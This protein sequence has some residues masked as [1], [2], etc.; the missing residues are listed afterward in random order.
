MNKVHTNFLRLL[1]N[2]L[3]DKHEPVDCTIEEVEYEAKNHICIPFIYKGAKN[4]EISIPQT[5]NN[6]MIVSALR[7]QQNLQVQEFILQQLTEADIPCAVL[8][9][10]TVSVNYNEPML[11]TLGDIDILVNPSDYEKAIELLCGDEY[12]DESYEGHAFHYKYT[13]RGVAVEIH[14]F[15]T[16]YSSAE[17][18]KT[19]EKLMS[20]ALDGVVQRQMDEFVF[21][22]LSNKHQAATL[23]LHTQRHFFENRLPI[24][25][26]CDW[27]MFVRHVDLHEWKQDV[28]PFIEKMGLVDF[29][30]ALTATVNVYLR[31]ECEEKVSKKVPEKMTEFIMQEFLNNGVLTDKDSLSQNIASSCSRQSTDSDSKI[32]S[33]LLF[34]NEIARNEFVLA[35]KSCIFLPIFWI[36]IPIRFVFRQI[37]GKRSGLSL[38]A[39]NDTLERKKYIINKLKLKD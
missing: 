34:L 27:A 35:R 8:K 37:T 36:Y 20:N 6:H 16:E 26:L 31:A 19:I 14:K 28:F 15:V 4:A 39:F 33:M 21:P 1:N 12:E 5:W 23:L 2:G 18:G 11:R 13:F 22:S 10:S 32:I 9:G 38:N 3:Y 25:M 17:Y 24:K 7:N 30:D 29:C